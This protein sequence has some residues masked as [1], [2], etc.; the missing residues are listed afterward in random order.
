MLKGHG[1]FSQY[2]FIYTKKEKKNTNGQSVQTQKETKETARTKN[3]KER[4]KNKG[5]R[6]KDERNVILSIPTRQLSE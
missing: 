4:N 3:N 5:V 1:I 2:F 6:K